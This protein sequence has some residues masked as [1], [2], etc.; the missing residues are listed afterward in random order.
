M[1][2]I[3]DRWRRELHASSLTDDSIRDYGF[4]S[5]A[6]AREL[7]R[8]LRWKYP[9][10]DL[11]DSLVIPYPMLNGNGF[12]GFARVKPA[13]SREGG[14]KYEQPLGEP[15]RAYPTRS[16][17]RALGDPQARKLVVVTEGEKKAIA[18][19]QAGFAA[20]AL[21][22][23]WNC[24]ESRPKDSKGRGTGER[25]L[26]P[27]LAA[28]DWRPWT[29]ILLYDTDPRRNPD[30]NHARAEAARIW[31]NSDAIV[32]L[33]DLPVGP[34]ENDGLPAKMGAD[35]FIVRF[36]P[37]EF[38]RLL[39]QA[40]APPQPP[41]SL[42]NYRNDLLQ[43]RLDS[44][45]SPGLY[46]DGSPTGA[47][48]SY[49]DV[50][51]ARAAGSSLTI[52]PCHANCSELEED[53][54]SAEMD[55]RAFPSLTKKTC[56][57]HAEAIQ[58][59]DAGLAVSAAVCPGC[60]HR[61]DCDY[62][63]AMKQADSARHRIAC[64]A[65]AST[66]GI[67]SM[68]EG[69][70]YIAIHEDAVAMLRPCVEIST[71]LDRV[72][73]IAEKS[74]FD[75]MDFAM[76]EAG[77]FYAMEQ[78]CRVL[79]DRLNGADKTES[80]TMPATASKPRNADATLYRT[81]KVTNTWP[82]GDVL[83]IVRAAAAGE[84]AELA[85]RVDRVFD[86]GGKETVRR[87]IVG[88]W[89]MELPDKATVW[90]CDAT[91]DPAELSRL[92]GRPVTDKTPIGQLQQQHSILQIPVDVKKSTSAA[93]VAKTLRG[94]LLAFAGPRRI[95]IICDRRHVPVIRG[96]SKAANVEPAL[97]ER[98][99]RIEYF[100]GGEGRA[101]NEWTKDC[102][103]LIVFG[104]PRVPPKAIEQYL[105]RTAQLAAADRGPQ[106]AEWTR[107]Y[108]SAKTTEGRRLTIATKAYR[109][110]A[111]HAAHRSLVIA[112]LLQSVGRARSVCD[113]GIPAVVVSTEDLG[114]EI[115]PKKFQPVTNSA[116]EVFFLLC[117]ESEAVSKGAD[118]VPEATPAIVNTSEAFSKGAKNAKAVNTSEAFPNIYIRDRFRSDGI[119]TKFLAERLKKSDRQIRSLLCDLETAGLAKRLGKH[120]PWVPIRETGPLTIEGPPSPLAAATRITLAE[121]LARA[122]ELAAPRPASNN[123]TGSPVV[124]YATEAR[125]PQP[126]GGNHQET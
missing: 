7:A 15:S 66:G 73:A 45:G 48:K 37:D 92:A 98:I 75:A 24:F 106:G 35:D 34:N 125:V 115:S 10:R 23:V 68:A 36:G 97:R 93:T 122:R 84:L 119:A 20:I 105:I 56:G 101:S 62:Q 72:A 87:S 4:Y 74:R 43:A 89:K 1:T 79:I 77:F 116:L 90:L 14:G 38:R 120:G 83:R 17:I 113:H 121:R 118:G 63:D 26:L 65:R 64:H 16:F 25:K 103:L 11:G 76:G 80:L 109:D 114:L 86:A 5:T 96:T 107:D 50:Q 2:A 12:N 95:G 39:E 123:A 81:M 58:A 3:S 46:F 57:N 124:A 55:A 32:V 104:T 111:W 47:G 41:R 78:V 82:N 13:T 6:N 52:L 94:V 61:N 112:E 88:V 71:G 49:A 108:W 29:V 110:H 42:A 99:A 70:A 85:V 67:N 9:A 27:E 18:I 51:A 31:S 100:R 22:G 59:I 28:I 60:L 30:V 40:V 8:I 21:S 33:F 53:M 44:V 19:E 91:G 54:Q 126:T 102:D 117:S 69:I